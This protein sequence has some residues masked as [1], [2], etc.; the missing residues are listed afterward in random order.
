[1]PEVKGCLRYRIRLYF[2]LLQLLPV[3]V[4]Y[5]INLLGKPQ[6]MRTAFLYPLLL[7]IVF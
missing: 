7:C 3:V 4:Y 1:M 6:E 2:L 5:L